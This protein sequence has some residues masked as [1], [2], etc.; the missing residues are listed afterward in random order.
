MSLIGSKWPCVLR[1]MD[2]MLDIGK[3]KH[4]TLDEGEMKLRRERTKFYVA[5]WC[6]TSGIPFLAFNAH[7]FDLMCEAINKFGL[8]SKGPSKYKL[9]PSKDCVW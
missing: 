8:G 5:Q 1:P 7:E 3:L 9:R 2:M 6:Y 4:N